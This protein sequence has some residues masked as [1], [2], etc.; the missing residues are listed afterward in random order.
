MRVEEFALRRCGVPV[1]RL[2]PQGSSAL[3][4]NALRILLNKIFNTGNFVDEGPCIIFSEK[5]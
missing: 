4:L 5:L 1:A 3:T 2:T